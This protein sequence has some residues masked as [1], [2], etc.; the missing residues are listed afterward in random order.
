MKKYKQQG[1]AIF[2]MILIIVAIATAVSFLIL[3][4]GETNNL[5]NNM[6]ISNTVV[7]QASL[8]RSSVLACPLEYP[9][10]N[11]GTG[12]NVSY[13]KAI[14]PVNAVDLVCPGASANLWTLND[15]ASSPVAPNGFGQWTYINNSSGIKISLVASTDRIQNLSTIV[16]RLGPQAIII[17]GNTLEWTIKS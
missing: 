13:P 4:Q 14:T 6:T 15:G 11:N 1:V 3:R 7:A 10:G 5:L 17:N 12:F 2:A 9:S 8:I 16:T